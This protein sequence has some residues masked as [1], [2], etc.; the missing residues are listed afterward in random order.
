LEAN[1]LL[2]KSAQGEADCALAAGADVPQTVGSTIDLT[3]N[4][5]KTTFQRK[6][7][8]RQA[9]LAAQHNKPHLQSP[10]CTSKITTAANPW[11]PRAKQNA[12]STSP[13]SNLQHRAQ[14]IS[15]SRHSLFLSLATG[16]FVFF[17]VVNKPTNQQG[18]SIFR[19]F[20]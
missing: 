9:F 18:F 14:P 16:W 20:K 10:L 1:Y 19:K 13:F 15:P 17:K 3:F 11:Q 8:A 5:W 4:F 7:A 2:K 6:H 12:Q